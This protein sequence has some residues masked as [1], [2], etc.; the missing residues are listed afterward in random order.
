MARDLYKDINWTAT[1]IETLK[2]ICNSSSTAGEKL[3]LINSE[4]FAPHNIELHY[5]GKR[6]QTT[7]TKPI[8]Y[9][10]T[11]LSNIKYENNQLIIVNSVVITEIKDIIT[12]QFLTASGCE[13][14]FIKLNDANMNN[15]GFKMNGEN[16]KTI[17]TFNKKIS[18]ADEQVRMALSERDNAV[19]LCKID[20][21]Y[22]VKGENINKAGYL[23]FPEIS[24]G[25]VITPTAKDNNDGT[26]TYTTKYSSQYNGKYQFM[27]FKNFRIDENTIINGLIGIDRNYSGVQNDY[28][29]PINIAGRKNNSV[30]NMV[31]NYILLAENFDNNYMDSATICEKNNNYIIYYTKGSKQ[32]KLTIPKDGE[33]LLVRCTDRLKS[34]KDNDNV[35]RIQNATTTLVKNEWNPESVSGST[36][37][38]YF[39]NHIIVLNSEINNGDWSF[40]AWIPN[41]KETSQLIHLIDSSNTSLP[42][43]LVKMEKRTFQ[44]NIPSKRNQFINTVRDNDFYEALQILDD[45]CFNDSNFT[46]FTSKTSADDY[47]GS[48]DF[49]LNLT[50]WVP[51]FNQ[52]I[53]YQINEDNADYIN[54]NYFY[55]KLRL[56]NNW[57]DAPTLTIDANDIGIYK[58]DNY[59]LRGVSLREIYE[60]Y[61]INPKD[62]QSLRISSPHL[63]LETDLSTLYNNNNQIFV[64]QNKDSVN[65]DLNLNWFLWIKLTGSST[66]YYAL[67]LKTNNVNLTIKDEIIN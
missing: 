29:S 61:T 7:L 37:T 32:H 48:C 46:S 56:A 17:F 27:G 64:K 11:R 47:F 54:Y 60:D 67:Y 41:V 23:Y 45:W 53:G 19:Y 62:I 12:G 59:N 28:L 15:V 40:G 33:L 36:R 30:F 14:S 34:E 35:Y 6:I 31:D 8:Q 16:K 43:N 44:F 51:S 50:C 21:L 1:E 65:Y 9:E 42:N 63:H 22:K 4:I 49:T 38:W 13:L 25:E 5:Y 66:Y 26:I 57:T 18:Y 20:D 55:R 58:V 52:K 24:N 3:R 10:T 2:G 39:A